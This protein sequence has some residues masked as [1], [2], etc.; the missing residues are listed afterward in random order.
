VDQASTPSAP[1]LL[2]LTEELAEVGLDLDGSQTWHPLAVAEIDYALRPTVH[3]RRV[4]SYGAIVAP[5][6]APATWEHDTELE[7]ALRKVGDTDIA[8]ARRY[9]DGRSSWLVRLVDGEEA[10]AVFDRPAGS[11]RD[12]VVLAEAL[13]AVIVQRHPAGA[14]RI[15]GDFGVLRWNGLS[16]HREPLV[17]AWFDV[18]TG[19]SPFIDADILETLLEFAVHDLGARGIGATLVHMPDHSLEASFEHRLPPPPP[20]QISHATDLA[21]LRH[22]LAQVDG[23]TLFD[24]DGTL[25]AIG[26]R[27]VPSADAEA[28]VAAYRGTRHTAARRYSA[29]DPHATVIV[30]SEDG[31]VT[32]MRSGH[33]LG[34]SKPAG[35][36]TE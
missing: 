36:A 13:G 1:R 22:A 34:A 24:A 7:I 26:V 32:V 16:W 27:L 5:T 18:V 29:D 25:S 10:W 20:L 30:V 19:C 17:S 8:A 35:S 21:P 6:V 12:L 3:E 14:V 23:A 33:L 15:V 31:P 4:P 11:E 28:R 9:A 2:R